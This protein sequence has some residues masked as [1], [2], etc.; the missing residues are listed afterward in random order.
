MRSRTSFLLLV[1]L[2]FSS[3]LSWADEPKL[4]EAMD[5]VFGEVDPD[6]GLLLPDQGAP[7]FFYSMAGAADFLRGQIEGRL[8]LFGYSEGVLEIR[9]QGGQWSVYEPGGT[10]MAIDDQ[11]T[12]ARTMDWVAAVTEFRN[13]KSNLKNIG[14]ALEM[15]ST[16]HEGKYPASLAELTPDYLKYIPACP[17]A[18]KDTYSGTYSSFHDPAGRKFD[19]QDGV[20]DCYQFECAGHNHANLDVPANYPNY[21]GI[22]GIIEHP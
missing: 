17:A 15:W 19:G 12:F 9:H 7:K 1:L 8:F 5:K 10:S 20:K 18:G 14:T 4:P 22:R 2:F 11:A 21:N 16:D 3:A 13:C 6:H